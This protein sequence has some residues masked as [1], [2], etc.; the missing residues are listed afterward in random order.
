MDD[1]NEQT[2]DFDHLGLPK[3]PRPFA[4]V[5]VAAHCRHR[6]D[7]GKFLEN[8][9]WSDVSRVNDVLR[10]SKRLDRFRTKQTVRIGDH[11]NHDWSFG[12]L[13]HDYAFCKAQLKPLPPRKPPLSGRLHFIWNLELEPIVALRE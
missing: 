4:P 10:S 2:S 7:C 13:R 11:A 1:V 8:L 5:N 3:L 9:G 6:S 12:L